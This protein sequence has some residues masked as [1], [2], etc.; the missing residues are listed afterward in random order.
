MFLSREVSQTLQEQA[1][2]AAEGETF[3]EHASVDAGLAVQV[4]MCPVRS[5]FTFGTVVLPKLFNVL[6]RKVVNLIGLK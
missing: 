3:Q 1:G 4:G 2:E 6:F 5:V